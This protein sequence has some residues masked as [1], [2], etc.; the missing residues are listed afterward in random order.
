MR[1]DT[2]HFGV[3]TSYYPARRYQNHTKVVELLFRC[4]EKPQIPSYS[5]APDTYYSDYLSIRK[6]HAF[7]KI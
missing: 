6:I 1:T 7:P 5:D 2:P 3:R 4:I